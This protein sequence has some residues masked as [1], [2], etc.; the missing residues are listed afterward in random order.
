M[1]VK[2]DNS[3]TNPLFLQVNSNKTFEPVQ[4]KG[5][6][7]GERGDPFL[8]QP[9]TLDIPRKSETKIRLSV[10]VCM[11]VVIVVVVIVFVI[12]GLLYELPSLLLPRQYHLS[13]DF[14]VVIP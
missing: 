6:T 3:F 4:R 10:H 7:L 13:R 8:H 1:T 12:H 14:V 11:M 2:I 9:E 5:E